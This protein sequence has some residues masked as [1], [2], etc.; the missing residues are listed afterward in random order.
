MPYERSEVSSS[1]HEPCDVACERHECERV[2]SQAGLKDETQQSQAFADL[3]RIGR[4]LTKP[5]SRVLKIAIEKLELE[6]VFVVL[7]SL[8]FFNRALAKG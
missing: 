2:A 5:L 7:D 4:I 1:S 6:S 8:R 3:I